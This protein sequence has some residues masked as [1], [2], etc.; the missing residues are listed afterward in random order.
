M[1][2]LIKK[3]LNKEKNSSSFFLKFQTLKEKTKVDRIFKSITDSSENNEVRYVGG[4]IRKILNKQEVDDIDLATNIE[5]SKVLEILKKNNIDFYES[6]I[7]HGT[8]TARIDNFT[9]EITSLRK[10]I[11]TDGRHAKVQFSN[12]WYEDASRRDF[13]FN[14]IYADLNGNLYDPFN[15]KK[16]LEAGEVNFIGDAET[17]IKEDYLRILRYIRFFLNYSKNDHSDEI[18]KIIRQNINGVAQISPDRLLNELKKLYR[19][20][21]FLKLPKD[22]F[23]LEIINLIFPQLKNILTFKNIKNHAKEVIKSNDFIF[24]I[25]LMIIDETDNSEYFLYKFNI[26]N[27]NKKRIR[28]LNNIFSKPLDKNFFSEKNLWKILYFHGNQHLNDLINFKIVKNKKI[29]NKIIKIK[30]FF[31]NQSAHKFNIKAKYLMEKFNMKEGKE[32][33]QKLKEIETFWI[34]NSFKI[35]DKQIEK[36]IEN[37]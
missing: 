3:F 34:D 13:T 10:D 2:G 27:E 32:L 24:L 14:S 36:I 35:T 12:S 30:K 22:K 20:S 21:G 4:C 16:D 8:V 23:C 1:I 37:Y 31:N 11:S 17:R 15:G 28:F 26:S 7:E 19:T 5:P 25:S 18:Q 29:D 33:G 6:G 9:F